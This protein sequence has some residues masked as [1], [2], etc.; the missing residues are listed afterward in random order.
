MWVRYV[1]DTFVIWPHGP[2]TLRDFHDHLNQQNPA[3]QFTTEE[4]KEDKIAF[5]DVQVERKN[6]KARTSVY[7]KPTNT[8]R[9]I[10]FN[11]HHHP[12][13]LT[14]VV[15]CLG[16]RARSVC[17]KST[18][19]REMKHLKTVFAANGYPNPLVHR[20]LSR[21]PRAQPVPSD[22]TQTTKTEEK[23]LLYHL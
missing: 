10:H 23:K 5:L 9:Y 16:D 20:T 17:E 11:S 19:S 4:E 3:I 12:R 14:G 15:Q 21:T 18:I 1:D 7:H 2:E 22:P 6:N 8:D 13:I